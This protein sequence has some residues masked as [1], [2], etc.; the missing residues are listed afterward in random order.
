MS[1]A[2]SGLGE[3]GCSLAVVYRLLIAVTFLA[4]KHG[5]WEIRASVV[6][7]RAL[8]ICSS[9]ALGEQYFW[10]SGLCVPCHVGSSRT[11]D[12]THVSCLGRQIF[13]H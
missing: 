9:Q 4:V 7:A 2:S 6:A 5:L 1:G 12:Q 8:G 11:R 10:F 13:I 3:Q